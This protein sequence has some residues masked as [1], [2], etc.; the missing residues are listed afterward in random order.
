MVLRFL[1]G[2]AVQPG[3]APARAGVPPQLRA[4]DSNLKQQGRAR[5]NFRMQSTESH[6]ECNVQLRALQTRGDERGPVVR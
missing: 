6:Y 1:V 2:A 3:Q 5:C 4:P